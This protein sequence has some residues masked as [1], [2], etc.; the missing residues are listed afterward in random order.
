MEK[1]RV[2]V[3]DDSPFSQKVMKGALEAS[4]F[5]VCGF[6]QT[7]REGIAQYREL[8]PDAVTMDV[9]MPDMDGLVC[10]R[11][12]LAKWPGA[13]IVMVSAMKD[14][15]LIAQGSAIGIQAFLQ[16]PAKADELASVLRQVC[17]VPQVEEQFHEQY[18]KPFQAAFE[19]TLAELLQTQ[20]PVTVLPV[21]S[22]AFVSQGLAI[23]LGVTGGYQGRAILDLSQVT[24]KALAEHLCKGTIDDQEDVLH[25]VAE[26]A[27]IIGGHG[28]S[29]INHLFPKLDLRLTPP[30][31][32][33]GEAISIVN[34]KLKSYVIHAETILG[35]ISFSVGFV[36]GN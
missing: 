22:G 1:I 11:E 16:K 21:V 35:P 25:C 10:S 15:A 12:I 4:G 36:G 18:I 7:G 33:F 5:E 30:S 29:R 26:F 6:A 27:N 14:E 20:S 24:A 13:H 23:V 34:P 2:L 28:V 17:N 19:E 32:L 9:T 3:V 8:Q 31:I